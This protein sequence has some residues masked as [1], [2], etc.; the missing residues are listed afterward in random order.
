M[1]F[2]NFKLRHPDNILPWGDQP[3]TSMDWT[4]LTDGE[5]W[6]DLNKTTLYEYTNEVL[7]GGEP[8]GSTYVEYQLVR[9]IEDWTSLFESIAEPVPDAFYAISR[10]NSY[11]YRFY[12]AVTKWMDNMSEDP[13]ID[14]ETYDKAIEWIYSRTLNAMHLTGGPSISFFRN[15][16]NISVVW[17]ADH[18]TEN[19]ISVWTA[20]NGSVEM[21]YRTFVNEMED[22]GNRFFEA[23]DNQ[24]QIAIEKDWGTTRLNKE[25]LVQEHQERRSEFQRSLAVLKGEPAKHTD[26]DLINSL[27]TKMFS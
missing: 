19:N 22:F 26:W 2:I 8:D 9:L 27:I 11:L 6:L 21:E 15:A 13:S 4:V 18:L 16:N 7:A 24:V 14:M 20:Q 1:A 23:M 5:Y 25:Q 12:A 10:D 17:K 3:D